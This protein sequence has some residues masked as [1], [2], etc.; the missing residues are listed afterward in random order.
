MKNI[1]PGAVH[2]IMSKYMLAD[3]LP[4]VFDPEKSTG[5][6]FVDAK[7]GEK[8][9]DFFGFYAT[10]P[11][12]YNM[13]GLWNKEWKERL[14][15]A[16]LIKPSL[17]DVYLCEQAAFVKKFAETAG[18]PELPHYFFIDGGALAVENALKAAFDWKVRK[19]LA[20][21][22]KD[23]GYQA[24]HFKNAFHGRSGY[25]LSLT[26][27]FDPRKTMY[28]PKFNWPRITSPGLNWPLNE[29]NIRQAE[30]DEKKALKEINKVIERDADD[31]AAIIIE[32]IQSEGGDIH[33][34]G[35][36]FKALK[37]ICDQHEILLI[38]DEVQTGLGGTGKWWAYEH[39]NVTP[40]ILVFGK[41]TQVC[42]IMAGKRLDEVDS[43][44]KVSSR[45]NSTFG[46]N[47]VDMVRETRY[48]EYME[49]Y[50]VVDNAAQ[51]GAY[52]LNRLQEIADGKP[53]LKN[54][55]GR[56]LLVAFDM[57]DTS[58]RDKFIEEAFKEHLLLIKSGEKAVR[59]RPALTLTKDDV[60]ECINIIKKV[61]DKLALTAET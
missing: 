41:K 56:G 16:S 58:L 23:K 51:V 55:R 42:G 2:D 18:R 15:K 37:E 24:I 19:N 13:P 33:F 31:I 3:G 30:K 21:G 40:D 17:S 28:F 39:F 48:L 47:L 20:K 8:Y 35:E 43:V 5:A 54:V 59:M 9:L 12:G 6:Y 11:V 25:T 4:L 60:D 7:T 50:K 38:F 29:E 22:I 26:N 57:P 10:M 46:G 49:E 44:F 14:L 52:L 27:T 1:G 53:P 61:R 32:P 45:I 36:F 34:R